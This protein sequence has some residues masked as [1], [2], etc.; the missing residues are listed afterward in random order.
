[1]YGTEIF[2]K[3]ETKSENLAVVTSTIIL[4]SSSDS[5]VALTLALVFRLAVMADVD[6]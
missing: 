2:F 3:M 4:C 5:D 6:N 1:M